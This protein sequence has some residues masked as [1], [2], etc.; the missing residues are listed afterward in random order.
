M[1][2]VRAQCGHVLKRNRNQLTL[3]YVG[4]CVL[5]TSIMAAGLVVAYRVEKTYSQ[6]IAYE[7]VL[8]GHLRTVIAMRA[9]ADN[10]SPPGPDTA[11]T[12]WEDE[13]SRV[14]N[15]SSLFTSQ[16]ENLRKEMQSYGDAA[17]GNCGEYLRS[18]RELMPQVVDQTEQA[19]RALKAKDDLRF[20]TYLFDAGRTF[21]RLQKAIGNINVEISTIK[22]ESLAQNSLLARRARNQLVGLS[23]LGFL[24]VLPATAYARRISRAIRVF[25]ARLQA[26]RDALENRVAERTVELRGEV[27]ERRRIEQFDNRRNSVLE[28]VA[29]GAS[30]Q[31]VLSELALT[32]EN[33]C[34]PLL[35]FI[36]AT[37]A[38]L[39]VAPSLSRQ[40]V[41]ALEA[42]L[43]EGDNPVRQAAANGQ[44]VLIADSEQELNAPE[45]RDFV[46]QHNISSWW[47]LPFLGSDGKLLGTLS[48]IGAEA[49]R[50]AQQEMR[51]LLSGAR[52]AAL[53]ITHADMQ[54]EL[55]YRAHHDSLTKLPNR[56][57]CDDR[58][59]QAMARAHRHGLKAA[60]LCIDLD[61]FKQI[62]DVHGH[63]AGDHLL[64]TIA[65]RLIARLRTTDTLVRMGGD[66]FLAVLDDIGDGE[67]LEKVAEALRTTIAEP[68]EFGNTLLRISASIGGAMYPGDGE[69]AAELKLHADHA[70]YRAKERGR[71]TFQMFST[72]LSERLARRR[73]LEGYLRDALDHDGFEL[74]YQPQYT[75]KRELIGLEALLRFRA[76][77]LKAI[78]P[79]EFIPV[80]EQTGLILEIGDWVI[81]N[82]CRQGVEWIERGFAP[83]RISVNISALELAQVRFAQRVADA[84]RASGFDPKYLQI[85]VTETAV[86]G[87]IDEATRHLRELER[88]GVTVSVDDFGTGHSSL[89]YLHRLP[90]DSIKVDRSFVRQITQCD[91]SKAIVRAIVAMANSLDL[92][93]IAEGVETEDQLSAVA[94]AGCHFIQ[95]Y[96]F[97][98]PLSVETLSGLLQECA[99]EGQV[100]PEKMPCEKIN[101]K[102]GNAAGLSLLVAGSPTVAIGNGKRSVRHAQ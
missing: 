23:A 50:P 1:S 85:E 55:F 44:T 27:E 63:Q 37:E 91:E 73:Q 7:T 13:A 43:A 46:R 93:V 51:V 11:S 25:E 74:Y 66:E 58:I 33:F 81:R 40:Y 36:Q 99:Q 21:D 82:V 15:A 45:V 92:Q 17:F 87:N 10:A 79:G 39:L 32:M 89:S 101:S 49:R 24:L 30:V 3:L 53:A 29:E 9:L 68:V 42:S 98:R 62:N 47:S 65:V 64:H 57:V 20:R 59:N 19:G 41:S 84:I 31:Q 48:L 8:N 86:M 56:S 34:K 100:A 78:S 5:Q 61:E 83:V 60:V 95:G 22:D 75:L 72:E 28:M 35:C 14:H 90:I 12:E 96:L 52:L 67:D 38:G 16:A 76:P 71:N 97:S 6:H 88:L 69:S 102:A 2:S 70:M 77:E 26:E 80:A 94:K 18:V 54:E 4:L